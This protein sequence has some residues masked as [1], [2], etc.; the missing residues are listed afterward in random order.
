MAARRENDLA[1]IALLEVEQR[2]RVVAVIVLASG[3][4]ALRRR[5]SGDVLRHC[6]R[7]HRSAKSHQHRAPVKL[8]G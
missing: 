7:K 2:R 8:H 5:R 1:D 6:Q 4:K 3:G